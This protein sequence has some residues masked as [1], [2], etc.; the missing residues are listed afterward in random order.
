MKTKG[1]PVP[2]LKQHE[3]NIAHK[4]EAGLANDHVLLRVTAGI[5]FAPSHQ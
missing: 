3:R 2:F 1:L 5:T 4:A